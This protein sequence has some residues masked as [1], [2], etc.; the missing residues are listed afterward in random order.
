MR[1]VYIIL[2]VAIAAVSIAAIG[3]LNSPEQPLLLLD[4]PQKVSC[5]MIIDGSEFIQMNDCL[6]ITL[7]KDG[8]YSTVIQLDELDGNYAVY[9]EIPIK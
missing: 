8:T 2:I 6:T 5:G 7:L 9:I 3:F 1:T 4:T